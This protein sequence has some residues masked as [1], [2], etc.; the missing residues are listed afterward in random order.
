MPRIPCILPSPLGAHSSAP[1]PP[2]LL[3][4]SAH[5]PAF[6][7]AVEI[8][9]IMASNVTAN[10][11]NIDFDDYSDWIELHNN[12]GS[13]VSLAGYY[14]TDDLSQPLKW[15]IPASA[16]IPANGYILFW[17]DGFDAAPGQDFVR[18]YSPWETFQTGRYHT[19]FKLSADGESVGLFRA[20]Q[21]VEPVTLLPLGSSWRY[22]DTGTDPGA[23]WMQPGFADGSWAAGEAELGYGDGDETT[24]IG[25]GGDPNDKYPAYFFR[26]HFQVDDP[27]GLGALELRLLAD[28]GAVVYLNGA[29]VAR[30]RMDPGAADFQT[31]AAHTATDGAFDTISLDPSQF[32]AGDNVLAVSVHQ[33]TPDSSDVSF[34]AEL[35][36][37]I[38]T[39]TPLAE[40]NAI[41]LGSAWK[42]KDDGAAPAANWAENGFADAGWSSGDAQLGY[43][44]GDEAT[45]ISYGPDPG[46]K[47]PAT[48]FRRHFTIADPSRLTQIQCRVL[49]DDGAILYLNGSEVA[50]LRMP[51]GAVDHLTY[52]STTA[53]EDEFDTITLTPDQFIAGDNVFA[54]EVHQ[55]GA[56][57]S[58]VSFDVELLA[59]ATT[60]DPDE[61]DSVS[62]GIQTAD[63][64]YARDPADGQWRF[65]GE[66]TPETPN[67]TIPADEPAAT[68][69]VAFSQPGGFFGGAQSVSLSTTAPGATIRFTLD[70]SVPGSD[71]P[72]YSGPITIAQTAVLRARAFEPNHIP[73]PLAT[74]TYFIGEPARDMAVISLTVD[75]DNFFDPAIGIYDNDIKGREAPVGIEF[76]A[77]GALGFQ[78][79]AGAKI[80]GENIWRFAQNPL[81]ITL[82]G[83]YG[84]DLISYKIFPEE[85]I[86]TFDEIG[87]RNGGDNWNDAML[88]DAMAPSMARGQ[89]D[90]DASD[91]RPCALY[92]NG[93]YWGIHNIRERLG[94][95][96]FS[97]HYQL[98]AGE[99]DILSYKHTINGTELV[100]EEGESE[101][102][103]AFEDQVNALDLS[104]DANYA[105][106]AGQMEVDNFIDYIAM[107]D[108]VYESSWHHNQE[109]WR[110][111]REGGKWR[112]NINDIDRG[113][114]G[115]NATSS[116]IDDLRSR[117]TLFDALV[118][119]TGFRD[120]MAQRYAAHLSS[121][122]HPDRIADII[123][124]L[125]AETDPEIQR[126]IDRWK[127]EGGIQSL[128]DRQAEFDEIKQFAADRASNVY[129]DM[130]GHLGLPS[131]TA[132]L[133][134][135]ISPSAGSR[136]DHGRAD[137]AAVCRDRHALPRHPGGADRRSRAGL[138]VHRLEHR[139]VRRAVAHP[140]RRS[141]RDRQFPAVGR[142]RGQR[143]RGWQYHAHR[144]R[145]ALRLGGRPHHPARASLTVEAGA[146]ILM[147]AGASIYVHGALN[148][149]G[150]DADP[151][152]IE[153]RQAGAKWGGLGL[154]QRD[155]G[156]DAFARHDH[157][158]DPS[159][160]RSGQ[161][162]GGG[163]Q[164][165][166]D[167]RARPRR[168]RCRRA[169]VRPLWRHDVTVL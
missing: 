105:L 165:R 46:D 128:A 29:E 8:S 94:E 36:G 81:N 113:F 78:V 168:G 86:G 112:W 126:H 25:F 146:E 99:Y 167:P 97:N 150:T 96:Y 33:R 91:Y 52:A 108:F 56:N 100:L 132:D 22:S 48:F 34:D 14:L 134:V 66:P 18:E 127:D 13:A 121:T 74:A 51:A 98:G 159:G 43:G 63:V 103:I 57:S 59:K 39:G 85:A 143:Y 70:G 6:A 83:K 93:Q 65:F 45:E 87:L 16:T 44:E 137:V 67:D 27:A 95:A 24:E 110:S 161:P 60:G 109:F 2:L 115:G 11:D 30:I 15:A 139:R 169:S 37:T 120:R 111:R 31:Y 32:V 163:L 5:T 21:T 12:S 125:A 116:L 140:D 124:A 158:G 123:D 41:P 118:A 153:P 151:V 106:V 49:I 135:H 142:N 102:Y 149:N 157:G 84:D 73:G 40:V 166:L 133:T 72:A 156:I 122:F 38:T 20:G 89:M 117:H 71:S 62:F 28:D 7:Q 119:N 136:L 160:R 9:E 17:A 92:L 35:T 145:I 141:V 26:T 76:F 138:C 58:D 53:A 1:P 68:A 47:Y 130:R 155:R 88:R 148:I 4:A 79:N 144:R 104:D 80:A 50:R 19:N 131:G 3:I 114:V 101:G 82:R 147:P 164:L 129:S 42:F 23:A 107:V 69:A 54:V 154:R 90:N 152:V 64:T 77:D 55:A 61:V 75:P 10:P 162:E